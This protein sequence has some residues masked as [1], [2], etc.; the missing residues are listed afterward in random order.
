MRVNK[1]RQINQ[2]LSRGEVFTPPQLVVEI[3]SKISENVYLNKESMFLVPGCGMGVF[4]IELVRILVE[5]YGY[6]I[7]DAKSRVIGIDNRI[8]YINF[9]KRKGYRVYHLDF[10]KD[11]LP[12]MKFDAIVGNP[13]Y[14]SSDNKSNKLWIRFIKKSL[15]LSKTVCFVTPISLLTSE[16]EQILDIRKKLNE[17]NNLFNLS[18]QNI[19]NVGEK[20]VYFISTDSDIKQSVLVFSDNS[21]KITN[22]IVDRVPIDVN[23][24]IKISIFQKI[25][26]YPYKNTYVFDFNPNSNQTTPNRLIKQGICSLTKDNVFKYK[27]H[28]SA[29]K[30]LYS[31][32]LVT[33]Y[34]S[35]NETTFGKLKVILNYSGGFTGDKYMFISSNMVG[36]QMLGILIDNKSVGKNI[37]KSYSSKLIKW[38]VSEEK[39]GGFNTAINK[40]PKLNFSKNW[41]DSDLY[42]EFNLTQEEIDYIENYVG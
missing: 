22:N 32:D 41:S 10:L 39:T 16:S 21:S 13:P 24:H 37:I 7:D 12:M 28:H 4:M 19:F 11:E 34:S 3:L 6:S 15:S 2:N 18:K 8:K 31:K 23:D 5:K 35:N 27:I 29:S 38:Y 42:K 25:E 26:K 20:V 1:F 30:I 40:L 9:L 36:K 14:Q 17:K 33:K